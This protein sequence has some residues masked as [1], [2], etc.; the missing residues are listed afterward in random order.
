MLGAA[1][2]QV[3]PKSAQLASTG[4]HTPLGTAAV[5]AYLQSQSHTLFPLSVLRAG[6]KLYG[7]WISNPLANSVKVTDTIY[8]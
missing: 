5:G 8:S 4:C 2:D 6:L 1:H 7:G 3:M